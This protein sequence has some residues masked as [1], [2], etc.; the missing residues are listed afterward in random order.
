[1]ATEFVPG[2]GFVETG[3]VDWDPNTQVQAEVPEGFNWYSYI[4]ENP[5][6]GAAGIDTPEEA[7]LHY[8][9]WGY[10]EPRAGV[11]GPSDTTVTGNPT[12]SSPATVQNFADLYYQSMNTSAPTGDLS[13]IGQQLGYV[14]ANG[15][16]DEFVAMNALKDQGYNP[17][18]LATFYSANTAAPQ[19]GTSAETFWQGYESGELDPN[20][21]NNTELALWE[22]EQQYANSDKADQSVSTSG[23]TNTVDPEVD[24]SNLDLSAQT[25][26]PVATTDNYMYGSNT[27]QPAQQYSMAPAHKIVSDLMGVDAQGNRSQAGKQYLQQYGYQ[28]DNEF[29]RGGIVG[30]YKRKW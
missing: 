28:A 24:L 23:T 1:M 30:K 9:T 17:G 11:T 8:Q 14:D 18:D 26:E 16:Y 5:D 3:T 21:R 7:A 2:V 15:N 12:A 29:A 25:F 27:Y 20:Y 13:S 10:N 19:E 6:L 4:S 22:L